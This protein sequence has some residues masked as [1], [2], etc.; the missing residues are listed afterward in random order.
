[1]LVFMASIAY[2]ASLTPVVKV[3]GEIW[4]FDDGRVLYLHSSGDVRIRDRRTGLDTTFTGVYGQEYGYGFLTP[5]GAI[6]VS[7]NVYEWF[8]N[9][10]VDLGRI[11]SSYSLRVKGG[12]AIWSN[13]GELILRDLAVGENTS[14]ASDAGNWYNDVTNTGQV[15][16]WIG[17]DWYGPG[18][19]DADYNIFSY[20]QGRTARLTADRYYWNV[21]PLTDGQSVVYKKTTPCCS[22]QLTQITLLEDG[23]EIPLSPWDTDD[24]NPPFNYQ[25][26]NGWVAYKAG[27]ALWL[28]SPDGQDQKLS[29]S[30]N[31]IEFLAPNGEITWTSNDHQDRYLWQGG[32]RAVYLGR[33]EGVSRWVDGV[34]YVKESG[35]LYEVDPLADP[36]PSHRENHLGVVDLRNIG[37]GNLGD[38]AIL[39]VGH[40]G[41]VWLKAL[42]NTPISRFGT[43][44]P[45]VTGIAVVSDILG[46]PA[47]ELATLTTDPAD[48]VVQV[49]LHDTLTGEAFLSLDFDPAFSPVAMAVL[50]DVNGNGTADIAVLGIG[51]D[52]GNL[53]VTVKDAFTGRFVK[54]IWFSRTFTPIRLLTV[55]DLNGNGS[56]ELALLGYDPINR[57]A[58][59]E[60]RDGRFGSFIRNVWFGDDEYEPL[61]MALVGDSNGDGIDEIAILGRNPANGNAKVAIKDLKTGLWVNQVWFGASPP[62]QQLVVVPDFSG[63]GAAEIGLLQVDEIR[64]Q[65]RVAFRDSHTREWLGLVWAN[66]AYAPADVAVLPDINGNGSAELAVLGDVNGELRTLIK[67]SASDAWLGVVDFAP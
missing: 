67:D 55:A 61:D 65:V 60:L 38:V 42:D 50:D 1:M 48:N 32:P 46:S 64:E 22:N 23:V 30:I 18:D 66:A 9:G 29:S 2:S 28:R 5:G 19:T 62:A 57:R 7:D 17:S 44:N 21:Y 63:N 33:A 52:N 11:N 12:F 47:P 56:Q 8:D 10:I 15:V 39:A 25:I 49:E 43:E 13:G 34:W 59:V 54:H 26:N 4:D 24:S 31:R 6:F 14:V 45:R 3:Y 58:K 40:D 53:R 36:V 51:R 41:T 27:S 16:Y 37:G 35:V 20:Y